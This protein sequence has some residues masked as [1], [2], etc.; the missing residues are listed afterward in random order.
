MFLLSG[1]Y[2]VTCKSR[3]DANSNKFTHIPKSFLLFSI[4]DI[5]LKD[6]ELN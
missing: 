5:R 3:L 4:T 6:D 1:I 2:E